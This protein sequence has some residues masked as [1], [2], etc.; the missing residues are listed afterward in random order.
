MNPDILRE[1][2]TKNRS[3]TERFFRFA[4]SRVDQLSDVDGS[5]FSGRVRGGA[6]ISLERNAPG[7][8]ADIG[9]ENID[10]AS[11]TKLY[12]NYNGAHGKLNGRYTFTGRGDDARRMQGMGHVDVTNGSI[13]TIP[14]LGPLT[15]ILNSIVPGMGYDEARMA[16]ADFRVREGAID[17]KN[18]LVTGHGFNM[19]GGGRLFFLDDKMN[20]DVRIN[21]QGLPGVVLF[22]VS[23]LFEYA[24]DGSIVILSQVLPS[25][26][27]LG[28][29]ELSSLVVSKINNMPLNSLTDVEKAVKNPTGGFQK[30]EFE[31]SPSVIYLDANQIDAEAGALMR[32]Y[33][34]PA[35]KRIE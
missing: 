12:F 17:T 29:E 30:I 33:G 23:K 15:G 7:H 32:N 14:F 10:F 27:T 3:E 34:L 8:S 11:L 16:S 20:F 19:I 4:R 13:F 22:P 2:R 5:L 31:Q 6:E 25:P 26:A 24:S 35:L 18:F 21:A 9:V 1:T 28:Y